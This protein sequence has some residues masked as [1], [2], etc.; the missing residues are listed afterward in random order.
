MG[1]KKKKG[2]S[3]VSPRENKIETEIANERMNRDD[4]DDDDDGRHT[5][6][7]YLPTYSQ[8]KKE[9][10]RRQSAYSTRMINL[11][12][13]LVYLIYLRYLEISMRHFVIVKSRYL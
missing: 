4:D 8:E 5:K 13:N 1:T 2:P 7:T 3:T 9:R 6:N 12:D 10:E 11:G